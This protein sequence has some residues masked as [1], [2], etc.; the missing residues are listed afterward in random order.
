VQAIRIVETHISWVLLTGEYAY[1]V[2]KPVELPFLDFSTLEN[3]LHFC[4]E[5]LRLNR[6]LAA[7]L[8]LEVVPIGG[9]RTAPRIGTKPAFEYAIKMRQ[10]TDDARLDRRLAANALPAEALRVFAQRLARFHAELPATTSSAQ[11]AQIV[12]AAL[13]NFAELD[14]HVHGP[15]R[16]QLRALE[17]WTNRQGHQLMSVLGER[18]ATGAH[19]E[20]HGDLHLENLL[21]RGDEIVAFDA[22]E[23]DPK[24]RE[25]DVLSEASFL[26][27][28]LMAHG[29]TDLAYE[30]LNRYLEISGD[31]AGLDVLRFYLVYR[32]LVRAKVRAI[33]AAQNHAQSGRS[34]IA[35]YLAAASELIEASAP[36]LLITHGLSGSGKTHVTNE[37][38]G[39]LP[40]LRVRSDLERKR[41]RGLAAHAH[42]ESPVGGGL[43]DAGSTERTYA[44]LAWIAERALSNG[45][46][47][48][49]DA[50]FL[51]RA[52]RTAFRRLATASNARFAILECTA[53]DSELRRRIEARRREDSDASEANLAVLDHQ[54]TAQEP[55]HDSE[56]AA[57]VRIDTE[58]A[59]DYA[60][61]LA[62]ITGR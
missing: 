62:K 38:I 16:E 28:D 19:R 57:A 53:A 29:R 33:K 5:E 61:V 4:N 60:A 8:Y 41:L 49:V 42:S 23:F 12:A 3:R 1:K 7:D 2:K 44:A 54:L 10:F 26:A 46:S 36:Q 52:E 15:Q 35:S 6:R 40:A 31:Y 51:R 58:H 11:P 34:A 56:R 37:L 59:I 47:M 45:F 27:M 18:A 24:L 9:T 20:C 30:F 25:I 21:M 55:L 39:A 50:T 32:A 43:Y 48:I 14:K 13:D 22:L 17:A